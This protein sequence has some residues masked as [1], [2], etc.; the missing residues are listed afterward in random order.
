MALSRTIPIN[1]GD[2]KETAPA[3]IKKETLP[4]LAPPAPTMVLSRMI[5]VNSKILSGGPGGSSQVKI[6][7]QS[8][9]V[10]NRW[11]NANE[12]LIEKCGGV[13][14]VRYA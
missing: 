5:P 12:K 4:S 13:E 6:K 14:E 10:A 11:S 2:E 3:A 7:R 1:T 8:N 9:V